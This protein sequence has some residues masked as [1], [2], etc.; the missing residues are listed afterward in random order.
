MRKFIEYFENFLS[1]SCNLLKLITSFF[2]IL[3]LII[4]SE[5]FRLTT[6]VLETFFEFHVLETIT[7]AVYSIFQSSINSKVL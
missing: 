3:R 4:I 1:F 7:R 6:S 2:R 5:F